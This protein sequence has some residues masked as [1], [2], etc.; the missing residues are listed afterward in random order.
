M[1]TLAPF[2]PFA[3]AIVVA[4]LTLFGVLYTQ[5]KTAEHNWE[6]KRTEIEAQRAQARDDFQR[7]TLMSVQAVASSL[8]NAAHAYLRA[9]AEVPA[10][11]P[12]FPITLKPLY[13]KTANL[14]LKLAVLQERVK[15][16]DVRVKLD[17]LVSRI[18]FHGM[19][20]ISRE[21]VPGIA[22]DIN[23]HYKAVCARLGD[24]LR[25]LL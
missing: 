5:R 20:R 25:D 16:V 10:E 11:H 21:D 15:D 18:A 14:S 1:D 9:L 13:E 22:N 7:K 8:M 2:I 6:T 4:G 3:Q 12:G 23:D 17:T 24:V 19:K